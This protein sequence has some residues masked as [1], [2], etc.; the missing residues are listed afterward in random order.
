MRSRDIEAPVPTRTTT[1]SQIVSR[2]KTC[3]NPRVNGPNDCRFCGAFRNTMPSVTPVGHMPQEILL[4]IFSKLIR[5]DPLA[6]GSLLFVCHHWN[7]IICGS[8]LLWSRISVYLAPHPPTIRRWVGYVTAATHYSENIPLHVDIT[9]PSLHN[10][11]CL[12]SLKLL[13]LSPQFLCENK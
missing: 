6:I 2:E 13:D 10:L 7:K 12:F 5:N 3:H 9:L 4:I 8:P 11:W 1:E